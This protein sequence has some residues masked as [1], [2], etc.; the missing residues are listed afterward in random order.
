MSCLSIN[1]SNLGYN[2]SESEENLSW[3]NILK[4]T[5]SID[6]EHVSKVVRSLMHYIDTVPMSHRSA[7]FTDD[8]LKQCAFKIADLVQ[9]I[10]DYRF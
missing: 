7:L 5:I 1:R 4:R 3:E 9:E 6:E 10:E 2:D 8:F